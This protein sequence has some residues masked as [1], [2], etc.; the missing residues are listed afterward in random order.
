M[1]SSA[2]VCKFVLSPF[3]NIGHPE[4]DNTELHHL[5]YFIHNVKKCLEIMNTQQYL[6]LKACI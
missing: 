1:N 3:I 5:H 4:L 2:N 6:C